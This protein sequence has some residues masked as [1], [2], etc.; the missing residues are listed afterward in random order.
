MEHQSAVTYGNHFAN[1]Y[2]ER[3]WTGVGI[4]PKFD[5]II[6]H[7]SGHEWFG[8]AR[9]GGRRVRHVDP[10]GLDHLPRVPVRRVHVRPRRRAEV[11]QRL[12]DQGPQPASRSSRSAA[13][14][15]TPPQDMYFKG[16]LFLHTLR[17]VIDDDARWWALHPRRV[18]ALQVPEH[19][20]R[21]HGG[22]L[23]RESRQDLT[24]I[25]DQ[26]LR[27]AAIARARA[28]VRRGRG[29]VR[30]AGRPTS[31]SSRCRC[32]WDSRSSGE[33]IQPTAEW[34]TMKT[35]LTKDDFEVATDLYYVNVSKL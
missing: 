5:F 33:L 4:S 24:P 28:E 13:S 2:L 9:V 16:A 32:G 6:I 21:G 17:S 19:H 34:Q 25:F 8:N 35:V 18:P 3:D 27:H 23:Q 22:V 26:Y 1:G 11:H 15:A 31:R 20:D 30:I 14:T 29:T 10:R 12:Q 7:E